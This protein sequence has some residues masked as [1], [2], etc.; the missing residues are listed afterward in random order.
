MFKV[1]YTYTGQLTKRAGMHQL[2]WTYESF[3]KTPASWEGG[4]HVE[5]YA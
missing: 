4:I 3:R 2:C 5:G 1:R